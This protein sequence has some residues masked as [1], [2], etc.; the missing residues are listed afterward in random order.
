MT[1][2]IGQQAFASISFNK[3]TV[4]VAKPALV[5]SDCKRRHRT[6]RCR[7]HLDDP[8]GA[9]IAGRTISFVAGNGTALCTATTGSD[10]KARA[11]GLTIP[12]PA[13]LS[14]SFTATFAG[15]SVYEGVNTTAQMLRL[16]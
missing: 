13:F 12:L 2:A 15:D 10:G 9:P 14:G 5:T 6:G 8:V 4:M 7:R 1:D 16:F 3:T 11:A